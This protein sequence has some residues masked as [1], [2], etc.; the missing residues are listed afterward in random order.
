[1]LDFFALDTTLAFSFLATAFTAFVAG[2]A[3]G[4]AVVATPPPTRTLAIAAAVAAR[5]SS[6]SLLKGRG[7]ALSAT[8]DT[9]FTDTKKDPLAA[10]FVTITVA[11]AFNALTSTVN[12]TALRPKSCQDLQA[13]IS[14]DILLKHR[15]TTRDEINTVKIHA[16]TRNL[17]K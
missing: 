13:A 7:I 9:P 11:V 15:V 17:P 14:I 6:R 12:S 2:A 16:N 3:G 8:I 4:A 1:M 5:L 10:G